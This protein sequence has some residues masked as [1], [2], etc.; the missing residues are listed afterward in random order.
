MFGKS[1]ALPLSTS[2][3]NVLGVTLQTRLNSIVRIVKSGRLKQGGYVAVMR[4][5]KCMQNFDEYS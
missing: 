3:I 1:V 4:T 2:V 5:Q